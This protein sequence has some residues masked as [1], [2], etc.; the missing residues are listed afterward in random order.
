[1]SAN[2][3]G[4]YAENAPQKFRNY[5]FNLVWRLQSFFDADLNTCVVRKP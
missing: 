4:D 5:F 3:T 1:M 2:G